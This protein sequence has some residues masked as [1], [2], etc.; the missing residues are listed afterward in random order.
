MLIFYT[1][2][3]RFSD[4]EKKRRKS[5][6]PARSPKGY[7]GRVPYAKPKSKP[8]K[9][10]DKYTLTPTEIHNI[11]SISGVKKV[12]EFTKTRLKQA[13]SQ[14]LEKLE[15][16]AV[17]SAKQ[18][19][20][21]VIKSAQGK[22]ETRFKG[23]TNSNGRGGTKNSSLSITSTEVLSNQKN[24]GFGSTRVYK[25]SLVFGNKK[26]Q[27]RSSEAIPV[28]MSAYRS[29]VIKDTGSGFLSNSNMVDKAPAFS[30][31]VSDMGGSLTSFLPCVTTCWPDYLSRGIS[32][33]IKPY[34]GQ[35]TSSRIE[36]LIEGS[37]SDWSINVV[38]SSG[39]RSREN[40]VSQYFPQI[41]DNTLKFTNINSYLDAKVRVHYCS[42]R[43]MKRVSII[44]DHGN[45]A[46]VFYD[47]VWANTDTSGSGDQTT[48]S[49]TIPTSKRAFL[50]GDFDEITNSSTGVTSN[51]ARNQQSVPQLSGGVGGLGLPSVLDL[52]TNPDSINRR[53][54]LPNNVFTQ[55]FQETTNWAAGVWTQRQ[56]FRMQDRYSILQSPAFKKE[57]I[58]HESVSQRLKPGEVLQIDTKVY[59]N[60][61]YSY[62]NQTRVALENPGAITSP[63]AIFPIIEIRG[64]PV[65]AMQYKVI[66]APTATDPAVV[67]EDSKIWI[68]TTSSSNVAV[69][70]ETDI[71]GYLKTASQRL[72][73]VGNIAD[74]NFYSKVYEQNLTERPGL[75]RVPVLDRRRLLDSSDLAPADSTNVVAGDSFISIPYK[76]VNG[77]FTEA[78]SAMSKFPMN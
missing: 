59:R 77:D 66:T 56:D 12:K 40:L 6:T 54:L 26:S 55:A 70:T 4:S 27:P 10:M 43:E 57:F 67:S 50:S 42:L 69:T 44:N 18:G 2:F 62:S 15:D 29:E 72:P 21:S 13:G 22:L 38:D 47:Y 52:E 60:I 71:T 8:A 19:I 25:K 74:R 53:G 1:G 37:T 46:A 7:G 14:S 33:M 63:D 45:P 32:T 39:D 36:E 17:S 48:A 51:E 30:P 24:Q 35:N 78:Q 75:N 65:S 16:F 58:V 64:I 73:I 23:I 3:P 76:Q 20:D 68:N 9:K 49:L 61:N 34:V 28:K 5:M 41:I 31:L 11:E